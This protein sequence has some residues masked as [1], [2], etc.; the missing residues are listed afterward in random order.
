MP[1]SLVTE[2]MLRKMLWTAGAK[3]FAFNFA[4]FATHAG[5]AGATASLVFLYLMAAILI[6]VTEFNG[7]LIDAKADTDDC[8][9]TN[10]WASASANEP[11][12][13][14]QPAQCARDL[15]QFTVA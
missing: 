14:P 2:A 7:A 6:L 9:P 13:A 3:G 10:A 5:L 1:I 15:F 11:T 8:Q 4:Q 12:Q